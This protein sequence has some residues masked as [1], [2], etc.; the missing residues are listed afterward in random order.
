MA[1]GC[2]AGFPDAAPARQADPWLLTALR[3]KGVPCYL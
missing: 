2:A 3:L 1:G